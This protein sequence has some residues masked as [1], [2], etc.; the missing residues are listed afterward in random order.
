[1]AVSYPISTP[2]DIGIA[3][4]QLT[5]T[6]AIAVSRSPFTFATQVH[7]YSG[8][9]WSASVTIPPVRKDLAEPWVAFLLSLRGQYGTF[10]LGDPNM[11]S[12]QGTATSATITGSLGD[13]SVSV[14]MSGT[15]KAGDY[16]QLGSSGSARLHKVL[17][18]K[19]GNGTLEIWP[20]LRANY[21]SA[22]ATLTNAK[23]VFRLAGNS[24]DWAISN[25]S[26][27]YGI[28]FEAMENI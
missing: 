12:P 13:R 7:A 18:D 2:T 8:E 4:I 24:T 17:A 6:N 3:E 15:L 25:N 9:M 5:A 27:A 11:T 19:S 23:G 10:L 28:Q 14:S 21:S 16:L 1:M 22:S 20:A 26:N